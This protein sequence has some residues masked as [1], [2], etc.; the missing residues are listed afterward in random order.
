MALFAVW[1]DRQA[2]M[3]QAYFVTASYAASGLVIGALALWIIISARSA[4]AKVE[5]L[6]KQK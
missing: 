4:K 3:N 5:Q 1:H 2:D 6:E